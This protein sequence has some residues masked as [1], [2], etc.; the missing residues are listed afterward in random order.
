MSRVIVIGQPRSGATAIMHMLDAAGLYCHGMPPGFDN[1][2]ISEY[3]GYHFGSVFDQEA[4]KCLVYSQLPII[5]DPDLKVIFSH[6]DLKQ[7]RLSMNKWTDKMIDES[8][9]FQNSDGTQITLERLHQSMLKSLQG[10]EHLYQPV[11]FEDLCRDPMRVAIK[12]A[13]FIGKGDPGAMAATIKDRSSDCLP[14]FLESE[15]S[16]M[17]RITKRKRL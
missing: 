5:T 8:L 1:E 14:D 6:R 10:G 2:Q 4:G 13:T 17:K 7:Q 15:L 16:N 3:G 12:I 9:V 11:A